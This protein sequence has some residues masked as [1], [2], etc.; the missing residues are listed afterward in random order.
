MLHLSD[1]HITFRNQR[2]WLRER[3]S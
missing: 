2:C 1:C 3:K